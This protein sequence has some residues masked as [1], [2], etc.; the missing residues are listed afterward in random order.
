MD[1]NEFIKTLSETN[2]TLDY[3]VNFDK[4]KNNV[5]KIELKLNQLNYLIGKNNLKRAIF[6]LY[7]ENPKVFEILDILIAVRKGNQKKILNEFG[8]YEYMGNYFKSPEKIYYYIKNTGLEK[9]F[10]DRNVKNLIDYVFG[11]EVGLDTNARKNRT[12]KNMSKIITKIFE[13][14]NIPFRKEVNSSEYKEIKSLGFD[15]KVFDF[16]VETLK[17]KYLIEVNFYNSGGS[18]LNE[19]ARSYTEIAQKIN[20]YQGFEFVW[21]TDGK[22]WLDAKNKIQEAFNKIEKIYNL[23]TLNNFIELIK[24]ELS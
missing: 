2:A 6:D 10:K 23:H 14:N 24:M 17:K 11:I 19:V 18:K 8:K 16:V 3:F 4:V 15:K 21:I 22:G 9:V 13:N 5:R 12:G 20:Q 7:E 1:F